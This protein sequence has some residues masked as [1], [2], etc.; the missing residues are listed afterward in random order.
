VTHSIK[1]FALLFNCN[2][3]SKADSVPNLVTIQTRADI[4]IINGGPEIQTS[5]T[6]K[7][8]H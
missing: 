4:K 6:S 8:T 5:A 2:F 1:T 7:P 3:A